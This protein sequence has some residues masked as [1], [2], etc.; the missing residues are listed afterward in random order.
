[1]CAQAAEF[2]SKPYDGAVV[3]TETLS[4]TF[5]S[6]APEGDLYNGVAYELSS[7]GFWHGCLDSPHEVILD[8]PANGTYT[9]TIAEGYASWW[10]VSEGRALE[11]NRLCSE[12]PVGGG[13][14]SDVVTVKREEGI[15]PAVNTPT[16]YKDEEPP[17]AA[18]SAG[19]ASERRVAEYQAERKA[20][21][22]REH[23][24]VAPA[25]PVA[26]TPPNAQGC[27]VPSLI[28]HSLGG[29]R[30]LLAAAH[31][32]LGRVKVAQR[33]HGALVVARQSP[34][35]GRHLGP[36]AAVVVTLAPA[37]RRR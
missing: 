13:F 2:T 24:P 28:G 17:W 34:G 25:P 36:G 29:T 32:T 4:W 1:M 8:R 5:R 21:E 23:P 20:R 37:K 15:P 27:V 19:Q 31:C 16:P 35:R 11:A 12:A 3:S 6:T 26:V 22:E 18:A 10:L 14:A 33:K 9:I 7:E 30:R